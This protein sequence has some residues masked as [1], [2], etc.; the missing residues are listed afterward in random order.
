MS[1]DLA[2]PKR[3][4][5]V[6]TGSSSSEHEYADPSLQ[7]AH[8]TSA[9][10]VQ[11]WDPSAFLNPTMFS[12]DIVS[13]ETATPP[14]NM[15]HFQLEQSVHAP[16]HNAHV[17]QLVHQPGPFGQESFQDG[18]MAEQYAPSYDMYQNPQLG[19]GSFDSSHYR[20]ATQ[21]SDLSPS[22]AQ[23]G[24]HQEFL[25]SNSNP[26]PSQLQPNLH[27]QLPTQNHLYDFHQ[28]NASDRASPLPRHS[29][30]AGSPISNPGFA[31]QQDH[32]SS[33]GGI[34]RR[35]STADSIHSLHG[36]YPGEMGYLP[37]ASNG[38]NALG[39]A[40]SGV[41]PSALH[42]FNQRNAVSGPPYPHLGKD[43]NARTFNPLAAPAPNTG[44]TSVHHQ[45]LQGY[46]DGQGYS[47][48]SANFIPPHALADGSAPDAN[49]AYPSN[50]GVSP[51]V[52]QFIR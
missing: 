42:Q 20:P 17:P 48:Q 18:Y 9:Q 50:S 26:Y 14:Q 46:P 31:A 11:E 41:V 1:A 37:G 36:E 38:T 33:V 2:W 5:V 43:G 6:A 8:P 47:D 16:L 19:R 22:M 23:L 35:P 7:S 44:Y 34:D 27:A 21:A 24:L 51:E 39:M 29:P 12:S 49:G 10:H 3:D 30:F 32:F 13:P 52:T 25:Y 15:T 28:P 40:P 4:G 45:H